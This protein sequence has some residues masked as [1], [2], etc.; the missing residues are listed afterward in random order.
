MYSSR[1]IENFSKIKENIA[2]VKENISKRLDIQFKQKEIKSYDITIEM[3]DED[4]FEK[5][6]KIK[7]FQ[8]DMFVFDFKFDK[9]S[10]W[11][12][13]KDPPKSY[14]FSLE[15]QFLIYVDFL[16]NGYIKFK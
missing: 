16:R 9:S 2:K 14:S 8:Y 11:L 3:I 12:M 7:N 10:G 6:I 4:K 5:T 15:E 13:N 1:I